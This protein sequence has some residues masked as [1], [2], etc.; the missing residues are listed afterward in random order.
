M[1]KET[2]ENVNQQSGMANIIQSVY[3]YLKDN[4]ILLGTWRNPIFNTRKARMPI[5]FYSKHNILGSSGFGTTK[6]FFSFKNNHTDKSVRLMTFVPTVK[7]NKI[8][9]W[10]IY[11]NP[12][13][14]GASWEAFNGSINIQKDVSAT[15]LSGG[16]LI[17][18]LDMPL[19]DGKYISV[20][21]EPVIFECLPGE[22]ITIAAKADST[23][24]DLY[25]RIRIEQIDL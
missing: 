2:L 24:T 14:T 9:E 22:I 8:V 1:P 15:A 5:V 25:L 20:G 4:N 21:D 7:A 3:K 23:S 10:D 12:T 17:G 13:L 6:P 16:T 18:G 11:K 19:T